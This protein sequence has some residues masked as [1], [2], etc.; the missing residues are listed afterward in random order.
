MHISGRLFLTMV[1]V[2][3]VACERAPDYSVSDTPD[4]TTV[5]ARVI[6]M[7][8]DTLTP[9]AN[10]VRADLFLEGDVTI[11]RATLAVT[12]VLDSLQGAHP[13]VTIVR[14]IGFILDFG[15][16]KDRRVPLKPVLEAVHAP[17]NGD[18]LHLGPG[19][20]FRTHVNHSGALPTEVQ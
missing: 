20:T 10:R 18:T 11:E 8:V 5:T 7:W 13:N 6:E 12:A 19:V 2:L 14:G 17:L 15:A 16:A 9:E 3:A 1:V 4:L